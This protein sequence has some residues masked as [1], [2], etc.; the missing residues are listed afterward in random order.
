MILGLFVVSC[1]YSRSTNNLTEEQIK[2]EI[3]KANYCQKDSDCVNIGEKCPFGCAI[4][5]N[6]N[7]ETRI[8]SLVEPYGSN[9]I[10]DCIEVKE[11]KCISNKCT[12]I[13]S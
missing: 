4:I 10:Y 7:E 6:I 5:V 11:V 3:E 13:T 1:T 9:C 12:A 8:K 2:A